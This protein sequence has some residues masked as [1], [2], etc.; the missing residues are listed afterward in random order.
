MATKAG[1]ITRRDVK[2]GKT[3]WL[4][5]TDWSD[6]L[7]CFIFA[8]QRIRALGREQRFYKGPAAKGHLWQFSG[9]PDNETAVDQVVSD[10]QLSSYFTSKRRAVS[11]LKIH[12]RH[13]ILQANKFFLNYINKNRIQAG[14]FDLSPILERI[15]AQIN[16]QIQWAIGGKSL[17]QHERELG[18][19]QNMFLTG[20]KPYRAVIPA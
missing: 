4:I 16:L 11:Y 20:K 9:L 19:I 6:R 1:R 7:N 5:K 8:I 14:D 10:V 12:G 17:T 18:F 15:D 3:F 2:H 13:D